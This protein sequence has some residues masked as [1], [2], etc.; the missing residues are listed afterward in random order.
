MQNKGFIQFLTIV[1]AFACVYQLSFTFVSKSV[2]KKAAAY[3]DGDINLERAY[4]DSMSNEYVYNLLVAKFTYREVKQREINLGLDLKGG[5]NV[6]LEVSLGDLLKVMANNTDDETFN[7]AVANANEAKKTSNDDFISLFYKEFVALDANASL[8]SPKIFGHQEQDM[9][10][11]KMTND[12]VIVVLR[13]EADQAVERTFQ[14]LNARI[15]KFGVTQPNI[16]KIENTGR[17]VVELPGVKDPARVRQLLQGTAKLEFWETFDFQDVYP[18][19][20]KVNDYLAKIE[21]KDKKAEESIV[22]DSLN[23]LL[24]DTNTVAVIDANEEDSTDSQFGEGLSDNDKEAFEDFKKENP[25]FAVLEPAFAQDPETGRRFPSTG[26]V[27]GYA[28]TKDTAKVNKYLA[29][30]GVKQLLPKNLKLLWGNKPIKGTSVMAL[31]GMKISRRDGRALLE[32][33]V[34]TAADFRKN[35]QGSGFMVEMKMNADGSD[36]WG[37]ITEANKGKSVA[38]VLDDLV[39]SAPTVQDKISGGI[40]SITGDF[41]F[42]EA[43][44]LSSILKAGKLPAPAKIVE[45]AIVGPSLG[46]ESINK[47]VT[48]FVIAFFLVLVYIFFYYNLAGL[49]SIVALLAN[50][51]FIIGALASLGTTLTLPGIAGLVLTIGMSVDANV[52]IF[53]RI[54]EELADGKGIRLAIT[55]GFNKSLSAILDA[56]V[57]TLLT[58]IILMVFGEGPVKGF[59]VV[60]FVGIIFSFFTAIFITR[61]LFEARLNAKKEIRFSIPLTA[62][63]FKNTNIQFLKNRKKYYIISGIV[64]ALGIVSF[65]TKSFNLGVDLKGGRSYTISFDNTN[66]STS[67]IAASLESALGSSPTVK[68]FGSNDKVKIITKY[69]FDEA[70]EEVDLE[71]KKLLFDNLSAKYTSAITFEQFIDKDYDLGISESYIVG[72]TIAKDIKTKSIYAIIFSLIVMFLYIMIRFKGWQFAAGAIVALIHDVIVVLAMFSIFDGILPFSLEIDQAI[73][74]A[75]LTVIGY[76]I[77]DTVIVFDRIREFLGE[78]KKKDQIEVMNNAL[79]STLSRTVNTS[80]TTIFVLL[81]IFLFGGAAIKG[82]SFA[83]LVGIL[84]GTYSSLCIASSVVA[85][86]TKKK[87]IKA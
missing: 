37:K 11:Y 53:E 20:E 78:N 73:I 32:G 22:V 60:L 67:D 43:K 40:S 65:A 4:L 28:L 41:S 49:A 51:F 17:I 26:P 33:D 57:T 56:N 54:K 71:V 79:N 45:E 27:M 50:V 2:E 24:P 12:E 18:S 63:A 69:K 3:A 48:S 87:V 81:V 38:I 34:I 15:D 8:A 46:Q 82:M 84:V 72:P 7:K 6:T 47:G 35:E 13:K 29:M 31:Y 76:S 68:F 19:F 77:N 80:T 30:P 21:G 64:I 25:F 75:V 16:Q 61:M 5:M 42:D 36:K 83:L 9:I 85:D 66:I 23:T 58:A 52:I 62:N 1:L 10:N 39:Y 74:A 59:A 86:V 55:D 70:S 44:A 14:V